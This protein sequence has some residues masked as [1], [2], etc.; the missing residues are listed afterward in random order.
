[1]IVDHNK[2]QSD[3]LVSAV[4][5]LGPIEDKFRAFGWEVARGDG[6]DPVAIRGVLARFAEVND[7]PKVFIADT[8]K[9]KGLSFMEGLACGD[10]TYHFL[11]GAP[12]LGDY[13]AAPNELFDR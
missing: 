10:Q 5:D 9:G 12:A 1:V 11:A 3:S 13:L 2:L 7:K 8:I 4:S 6:H